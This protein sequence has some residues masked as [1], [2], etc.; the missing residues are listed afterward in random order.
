M[1]FL[2]ARFASTHKNVIFLQFYLFLLISITKVSQCGHQNILS[3]G[4]P[5]MLVQNEIY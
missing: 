3:I 4:M 1:L 2:P 5:W